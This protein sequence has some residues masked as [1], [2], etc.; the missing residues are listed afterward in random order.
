[1]RVLHS[2]CWSNQVGKWVNIFCKKVKGWYTYDVHFERWRVRE[3]GGGGGGVVN[4]KWDAIGHRGWRVGECFGPPI[5]FFNKEKRICNLTRHYAESN[6]SI[7][8]T[9]TLSLALTSDIALH[10]LWTKSNNRTRSQFE[11]GVIWFC[12]CFDFLRS[13]ARCAVVVS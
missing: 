5:F 7:L 4:Q 2:N 6:I 11:C 12:F 3:G 10:C 9:K 13:D 8:L 1:M